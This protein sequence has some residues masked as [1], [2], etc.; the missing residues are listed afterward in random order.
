[1]QLWP[2]RPSYHGSLRCPCALVWEIMAFWNFS[3][4]LQSLTKK[5]FRVQQSRIKTRNCLLSSTCPFWTFWVLASYKSK[6]K[7]V[8]YIYIYT[9][10]L[11]NMFVQIFVFEN[12][13]RTSHVVKLNPPPQ[14]C[15]WKMQKWRSPLDHFLT[16]AGLPH[17]LS[18]TK[19]SPWQPQIS[20]HLQAKSTKTQTWTKA[21]FS[22]FDKNLC[23]RSS[24]SWHN[25][26]MKRY[27]LSMLSG[28]EPTS[29]EKMLHQ[30][31]LHAHGDGSQP[32]IIRPNL[33]N[34][35]CIISNFKAQTISACDTCHESGLARQAK[36]PIAAFA[37]RQF[38]QAPSTNKATLTLI[39]L[40]D[41]TK[42]HQKIN[43][44]QAHNQDFS[45]L[46]SSS[47]IARRGL[48]SSSL[49]SRCSGVYKKSFTCFC[50]LSCIKTFDTLPWLF[51][52]QRVKSLTLCTIDHLDLHSLGAI[53]SRSLPSRLCALHVPRSGRKASNSSCRTDP[54]I[55]GSQNADGDV[56]CDNASV[57]SLQIQTKVTDWKS[58]HLES[59]EFLL[60]LFLANTSCCCPCPRSLFHLLKVPRLFLILF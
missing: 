12:T 53:Q 3:M 49:M 32:H 28:L 27:F 38:G 2:K 36:V 46:V 39:C 45:S 41:S 22:A 4:S 33:R 1:M 25:I 55:V 17:Q 35:K 43:A 56:H 60:P 51:P 59:S 52:A 34:S 57:S 47:F 16:F 48:F 15:I 50:E 5:L 24:G 42:E 40:T 7:Q 13:L 30:K 37:A 21:N 19:H 10:I 6:S 14:L 18:Q 44:S 9:V 54:T 20:R 8:L 29:C 31:V 23:K 58:A 11:S 26:A